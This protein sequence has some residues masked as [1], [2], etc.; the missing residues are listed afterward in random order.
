MSWN[1][2][3]EFRAVRNMELC[4]QVLLVLSQNKNF[5]KTFSDSNPCDK[6]AKE[7]NSII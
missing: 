7:W 3:T 1:L 4:Q 2:R 6:E 5:P